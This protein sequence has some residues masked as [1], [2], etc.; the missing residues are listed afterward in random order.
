[1]V[2]IWEL[3]QVFILID[4]NF[5]FKY[6]Q[7]SG[8]L[9]ASR[10]F[11]VIISNTSNTTFL[12]SCGAPFSLDITN[13][14][15]TFYYTLCTNITIYGHR[16]IIPSDPNCTFPRTYTSSVDLTDPS[17]NG[18]NGGQNKTIIDYGDP[19]H[20]TFFAVNGAGSG[21]KASFTHMFKE[22]SDNMLL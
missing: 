3:G 20:F 15:D 9:D 5:A 2:S 11:I 7:L 6:V 22:E 12:L 14:P 4:A 16:T 19:I 10:N 8:P 1:M 18:R 17:L 13:S 21:S